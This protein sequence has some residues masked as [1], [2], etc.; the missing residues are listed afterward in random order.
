MIHPVSVACAKPDLRYQ[1][2]IPVAAEA[3]MQP[4]IFRLVTEDFL[5]PSAPPRICSNTRGRLAKNIPVRVNK[6]TV[7]I[8]NS[9]RDHPRVND[10]FQFFQ[11][12]FYAHHPT[13]PLFFLQQN[14]NARQPLIYG[15]R[16]ACDSVLFCLTRLRSLILSTCVKLVHFRFFRASRN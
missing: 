15:V 4:Q 1:R 5:G 9:I 2:S 13:P 16:R 14:K 10:F 11:K 7:G 12:Y 3:V 6:V 8:E